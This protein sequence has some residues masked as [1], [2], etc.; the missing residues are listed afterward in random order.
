MHISSAIPGGGETP[1]S[2]GDFVKNPAK[3][4]FSPSYVG[5]TW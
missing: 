5:I 4:Y 3:S 1:G 2:G